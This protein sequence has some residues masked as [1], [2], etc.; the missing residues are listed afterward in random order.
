MNT[1]KKL[2]L[3]SLS[4]KSDMVSTALKGFSAAESLKYMDFGSINVT[5]WFVIC[6][7]FIIQL[8]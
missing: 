5:V 3:I 1:S 4:V 8:Y 2:Q 7:F 6:K